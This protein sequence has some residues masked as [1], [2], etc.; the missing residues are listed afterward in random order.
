[1][2][3]FVITIAALFGGIKQEITTISKKINR[4]EE[5]QDEH[6]NFI[7]RLCIAETKIIDIEHRMTNTSD[8]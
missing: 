3:L 6:N 5:K 1:M 2:F 8:D 4:L 7:N